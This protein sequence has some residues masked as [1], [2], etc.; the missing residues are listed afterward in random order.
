MSWPASQVDTY[1]MAED[2]GAL[3]A[4]ERYNFARAK[5]KELETVKGFDRMAVSLQRFSTSDAPL[6]MRATRSRR[7]NLLFPTIAGTAEIVYT[8]LFQTARSAQ[9]WQICRDALADRHF[10]AMAAE[11]G[12]ERPRHQ[13]IDTLRPIL[14]VSKSPARAQAEAPIEDMPSAADTPP[15]Q[16][17]SNASSFRLL[18]SACL[19]ASA[20][21]DV[22]TDLSA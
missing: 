5:Q 10:A 16:P 8:E 6:I 4:R 18:A 15:R 22:E 13:L 20:A 11:M 3:E 12:F 7:I 9:L 1:F 21:V 2:E 19:P 17:S 14:D